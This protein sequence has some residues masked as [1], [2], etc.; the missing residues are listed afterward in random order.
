MIDYLILVSREKRIT[1][2]Y[3]E[4]I[5][6]P[7]IIEVEP[8]KNN[9]LI[10]R[11]FNIEEKKTYLEKLTSEKFTQL[12]NYAKEQGVILGITSGFL[13]F[14]QQQYKYDYFLQKRGREF[15]EKSACMAGYSEHNTGLALDVDIFKNL[16]WGGIAVQEDGS[17]IP[18]AKWL[19]SV[20]HEFGFIL[21]YP[22]GEEH[23]TKMKFEPWHIRYVGESIA[24]YIYENKI[25]FE[26]YHQ[27]K[28]NENI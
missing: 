26:E 12:R 19:H 7:S 23:I 24:K 2:D 27:Q 13:T 17:I 9:D 25:T 3:Y 1:D 22:K 6:K 21:R 5:I 15:A 20:L 8:F 16:K 14:E 18:E 4:N 28:N 10:Y 11:I